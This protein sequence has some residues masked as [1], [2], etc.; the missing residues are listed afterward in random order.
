MSALT[1]TSVPYEANFANRIPSV[2]SNMPLERD[3][4]SKCVVCREKKWPTELVVTTSCKHDYCRVCINDM[5]EHASNDPLSFPPRCC[6][7]PIAFTLAQPFLR[8]EVV[9][10]FKQKDIEYSTR[11]STRC[12][13]SKCQE[14]IPADNVDGDRATCAICREMTCTICKSGADDGD[15]PEDPASGPLMATATEEGW[16]AC[17]NCHRLIDRYA[18]C[19]HMMYFSPVF[20]TL[21]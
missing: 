4:R 2:S 14:L 19:N 8:P 12:H 13:D 17:S 9:D 5:F 1:D 10:R 7:E 21:T 15:C 20:Q 11:N 16:K 18:G 6:G 3:E